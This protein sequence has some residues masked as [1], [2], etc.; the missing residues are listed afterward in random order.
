MY[1]WM[2]FDKC[3]HSWNYH[4]NQDIEYTQHPRKFLCAWSQSISPLWTQVTIYLFSV[5]AIKIKFA[6]YRPSYIRNYKAS[7]LLCLVLSFSLTVLRFIVVL[8]I[9]SLLL[10]ISD[11]Y[12]IVQMFHNIYLPTSYW[13]FGLFRVFWLLWK[14]AAVK[15][16]VKVIEW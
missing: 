16:H 10:F 3:L 15:I 1:S 6:F 12:S 4:Q 2:S 13:I 9:S 11:L 14:N 7:T 8:C 5:Q